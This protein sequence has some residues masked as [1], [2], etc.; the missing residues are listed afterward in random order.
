MKNEIKVSLTEYIKEEL[1]LFF[2]CPFWVR[3]TCF[4]MLMESPVSVLFFITTGI[5]FKY[6]KKFL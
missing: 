5:A 4:F 1:A 6:I 3:W 2:E